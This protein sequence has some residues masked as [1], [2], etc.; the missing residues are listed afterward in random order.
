VNG[1][2]RRRLAAVLGGMAL[3]AGIPGPA[4]TAPQYREITATTVGRALTAATANRHA[5]RG[6]SA[7]ATR[8]RAWEVAP[9][10]YLVGPWL[11][12]NLRTSTVVRGGRRVVELRFDVVTGLERASRNRVPRG[13]TS[14]GPAAVPTWAWQSQA[15][16]ARMGDPRF[17]W[18]DSCYLIHRLKNESDSRDYYKLEQYGTVGAGPFAKIYDGWLAAA[19]GPG[20]G[21]MAWVDWSPR[22]DLSGSCQG[23]PLSVSA[24]GVAISASGIMC[25]RWDMTKGAPAG[26]FRQMWSCGCVWPLGQPWPNDREIDYMQAVSVPNGKPVVWTLSA[27]FTA[28]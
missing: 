13:T 26:T 27:G 1:P 16:F 11:P 15:C 2:A 12:A 23:I 22:G 19:K 21:A 20:S 28:I 14:L 5:R 24:L 6:G 8:L 7:G 10:E 25:E 4:T 17:G 9:G 3:V 18:L